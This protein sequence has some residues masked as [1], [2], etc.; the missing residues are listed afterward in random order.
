[1]PWPVGNMVTLNGGWPFSDAP[2]QWSV[3]GEVRDGQV[4]LVCGRC[5]QSV[6][7]L[8]LALDEPGYAVTGDMLKSR[9][10]DHCLKVHSAVLGDAIL[11]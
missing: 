2:N 10:S 7:P 3:R 6:M 8:A 9:I 5:D 1:M 11:T 4:H